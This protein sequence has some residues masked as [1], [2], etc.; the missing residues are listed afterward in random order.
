MNTTYAKLANDYCN[1]T[2][3]EYVKEMFCIS[4]EIETTVY[5]EFQFLMNLVGQRQ[6]EKLNYILH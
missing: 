5:N 2:S 6:E 4:H 1:L 3:L